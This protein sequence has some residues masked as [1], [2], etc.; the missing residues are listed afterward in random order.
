MG[1]GLPMPLLQYSTELMDQHCVMMQA[2][3]T[4]AMKTPVQKAQLY[5]GSVHSQ[6]PCAFYE[7]QL[8]IAAIHFGMTQEG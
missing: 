7:Q 4:L 6:T 2:P 3:S 8:L 1:V 5:Y